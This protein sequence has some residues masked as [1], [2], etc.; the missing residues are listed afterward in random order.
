MCLCC[1]DVKNCAPVAP[2]S[3]RTGVLSSSVRACVDDETMLLYCEQGH[4][5]QSS[6][7]RALKCATSSEGVAMA[8][9][10]GITALGPCTTPNSTLITALEN[11]I[12]VVWCK[13]FPLAV[14]DL[15]GRIMQHK[16]RL[17][18][19]CTNCSVVI[20]FD[21]TDPKSAHCSQCAPATDLVAE[22]TN[23]CALCKRSR[24]LS[25]CV[26]SSVWL[27]GIV[28][29]ASVCSPCFQHAVDKRRPVQPLLHMTRKVDESRRCRELAVLRKRKRFCF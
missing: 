13:Q 26:V 25:R 7:A 22:R 6:S 3:K 27:P 19:L 24:N 15:K 12:A 17:Y 28:Q 20:Q 5:S 16:Q 21:G 29:T 11:A 14:I 9:A 18:T 1:G 2:S 10:T 4:N 23:F 8:S